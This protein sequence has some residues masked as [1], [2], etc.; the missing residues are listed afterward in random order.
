MYVVLNFLV[1][2][3]KKI[4]KKRQVKLILKIYFI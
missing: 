2:M 3:F 4:N 1:T